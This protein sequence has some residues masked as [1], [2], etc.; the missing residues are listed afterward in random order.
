MALEK[1][2]IRVESGTLDFSD[3]SKWITAMFNPAQLT[4]TKTVNWEGQP[5]AQRDNPE[6]QFTNSEPQTTTL[7]LIFDTYDR[8][9]IQKQ[10][11]AELTDGLLHLT[12]VETHGDKHRPPVC[13]LA[14]GRWGVFLTAVVQQLERQ[15]TLFTEDGTPVR[16]LV[17]TTFKQWRSNEHDAARQKK[18]SSDVAKVR[19]LKYGDTLT[20]IAAEEYRDSRKWRYIA[21]CNSIADPF[22]VPVGTVLKIPALRRA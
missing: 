19:V 8:P 3:S 22:A 7:D 5:A 18:E 21:K 2:V 11:V 1:L 13:Q 9:G 6:L 20:S 15:F 17:K 10:S 4:L 14:W 12:T 16:A